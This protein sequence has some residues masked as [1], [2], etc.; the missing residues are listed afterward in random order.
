MELRTSIDS[1]IRLVFNSTTVDIAE[2]Y[3]EDSSQ[4]MSESPCLRIRDVCFISA[5]SSITRDNSIFR[6]KR[7]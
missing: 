6:M 4:L 7:Y 5:C 2:Y 3:T 1:Q